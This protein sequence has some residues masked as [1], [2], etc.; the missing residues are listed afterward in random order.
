MASPSNFGH[1]GERPSHAE[2]LDDLA[3]RFMDNG[4]SIKWLAREIVLSST[5]RQNSA[6]EA[7]KQIADSENISLSRMN[8][9]RL[10]VEQWRDAVLFVSGELKYEGGK[11]LEL[12]DPANER[13]TVFARVSRLKLN[14]FLIQFD[15]PDAN[16]HA[17]K[18]AVTT[19]ATQKLFMLNSPFML[20]QAKALAARMTTS[21][22]EPDKSRIEK[23]YQMLYG[24]KP[25]REERALALEFLKKPAG[26]GMTRWEQLAQML[27]ASNE[28][29]YVD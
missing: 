23:T 14:D 27:L 12:D 21:A 18:R 24:R 17:E 9:R 2:L 19:T 25:Q 29:L 8:R 20:A 1:T 7:N 26:P 5:Y 10:S 3:I 22:N 11:S 28:F 13:R 16:V 6:A 15:Y 4:W